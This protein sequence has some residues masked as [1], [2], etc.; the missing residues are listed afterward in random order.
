VT[1]SG[2]GATGSHRH[3]W[4]ALGIAGLTA[5]VIMGAWVRYERSQPELQGILG[6][7]F[8]VVVVAGMV[9]FVVLV[10][11]IQIMRRR[12]SG[13][14]AIAF[15]TFLIGGALVGGWVGPTAPLRPVPV[16]APGTVSLVA[17]PPV[18][19]SLTLSA[20]CEIGPNEW[21][22]DATSGSGFNGGVPLVF[23]LF[24]VGPSPTVTMQVLGYRDGPTTHQVVAVTDAGRAGSIR[25]QG[26][27]LDPNAPSRQSF[28]A[29]SGGS[30][31][32][33]SGNVSWRCDAPFPSGP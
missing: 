3:R 31:T 4:I 18:S 28:P 24:F 15:A 25:F 33:F 21:S 20:V 17:D 8:A 23:R 19:F 30:P 16:D 10:G 14:A 5:G 29:Q 7:G 32:S 2:D 26:L 12:A 22:L 9:A 6:G 13:P 1:G 11:I 27:E